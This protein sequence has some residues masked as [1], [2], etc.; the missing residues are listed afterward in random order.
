MWW[1]CIQVTLKVRKDYPCRFFKIVEKLNCMSLPAGIP[2]QP[3]KQRSFYLY[4]GIREPFLLLFSFFSSTF[5][6][7]QTPSSFFFFFFTLYLVGGSEGV[8][9]GLGEATLIEPSLNPHWTLTEPSL[10]PL[11]TPS[12]VWTSYCKKNRLNYCWK[13][14]NRTSFIVVFNMTIVRYKTYVFLNMS[15]RTIF[16]FWIKSTIIQKNA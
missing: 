11:W 14:T 13:I 10:N 3:A 4:R 1:I 12:E 7:F 5:Y 9:R 8:P 16:D 15:G 2:I 6:F